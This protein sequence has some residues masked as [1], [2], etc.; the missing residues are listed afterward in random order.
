[1]FRVPARGGELRS[2]RPLRKSRG[3]RRRC[4]RRRWIVSCM[5]NDS[6]DTTSGCIN[7]RL[8]ICQMESFVW[9]PQALFGVDGGAA[10]EPSFREAAGRV[11]RAITGGRPTKSKARG[12]GGTSHE[13]EHPPPLTPPRS[14]SLHGGRGTQAARSTDDLESSTT[15]SEAVQFAAD[16]EAATG[17]EDVF[18]IRGDDLL[19]WTPAGYDQRIPRPRGVTVDVLTPP[20]IIAA[21]AEGYRPG[22]HSTAALVSAATGVTTPR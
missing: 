7:G 20:S 14:A 1:M 2:R 5:P 19:R 8:L 18:V 9:F 13:Q 11:A 4:A 15:R 21:L 10:S 12:V 17:A 16:F 6:M 3:Y 22:W